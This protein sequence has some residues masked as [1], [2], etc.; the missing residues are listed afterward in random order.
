MGEHLD[1]RSSMNS[2][3]NGFPGTNLSPAPELFGIIGL[4]T[5]NELNPIITL[6]GTVGISGDA[7][8]SFLISIVRGATF[9]PG[10]VIYS[11][12]G[13]VSITGLTQLHSFNLQDLLAPPAAETVYTAF[14][15]GASTSVRN[16]P[17]VFYGKA[18]GH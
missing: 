11:S 14:I 9:A 3:Q 6:A 16:G 1:M 8:D 10:N 2:N 4:Q 13:A 18:S 5:R 7:G 17:E 15:S 12:E